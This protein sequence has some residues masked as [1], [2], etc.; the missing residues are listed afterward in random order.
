MKWWCGEL[1]EIVIRAFFNVKPRLVT[2]VSDLR[3]AGE[4]TSNRQNC[5]HSSRQNSASIQT[6]KILLPFKP[7]KFYLHSLRQSSRNSFQVPIM[8]AQSDLKVEG[9]DCNSFSVPLTS[10][11]YNSW[12]ANRNHVLQI[13]YPFGF[14][15]QRHRWSD[16]TGGIQ[17]QKCRFSVYRSFLR[18]F[19]PSL[20]L[21]Q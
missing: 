6:V 15:Y 8:D 18:A 16:W 7:S 21:Q 1:S 11:V 19:H 4:S 20:C 12:Q 3:L 2:L 13:C 17:N 10:T 5:I 9:I 14:R